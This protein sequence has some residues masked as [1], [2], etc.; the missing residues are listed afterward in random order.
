MCKR[1]RASRL[2]A[3][4]VCLAVTTCGTLTLMAQQRNNPA[5]A[6]AS[7]DTLTPGKVVGGFRAEAVYTNDSDRPMGARLR[8][9]RTGFTLDYLQLQSV[10][11]IFLWVNSFPTSD[12]GEPHTQEHLLLGKG[13]VGRAHSSLEGMT[14]VGSS[15]FTMQW[16]TCYFFHTAAGPEVFYDVFESQVN[17][18]LHPDYSDEEI[19]REV[20]NWGVAVNPADKTLRLEE[21]GTVYQEM[22]STY[23]RPASRL[24]R[25]VGHM[26][27]GTTHPLSVSSGGWPADIRRMKPE[28]IRK[29]HADTHHLGNMG[30]VGSFPR[31]M[32]LGQTLARLDEIFKRLE[33]QPAK[34]KFMTEAQLPAPK[35][36]PAGEIRI[37]EYPHRNEQQAGTILYAWPAQLKLTPQ[38]EIL[39]GL[40]L[41]NFAGDPTTNLYKKFVDTK[42]RELDIGAKSVFGFVDE[43]QGH[44][45]Y[46]GFGD[47]PPANM[48]TEKIQQARQKITDEIRR[49][50]SLADGSPELREFN[51]R[52]MNRVI[53]RR[54]DLSKFVNSPPG[55]GFRNTS[56]A[57][58][59][60]LRSL[61]EVKGF[62]KSVT[63]KTEMAA[64]E[65]QLASGKNFWRASIASWKLADSQPYAAAAKPNPE[66]IRRDE[67]EKAARVE[68]ETARLKTQYGVPDAQEALRRY[69]ADYEKTTAEL[70][71]AA[72]QASTPRFIESP[73]LTLDDQLDFQTS[74]L[75]GGVPMVA[76]TFDNMTSATTGLALRLDSVPEEELVYLSL[77]PFLLRNVG[78]VRDGRAVTFEEMSEMLRKEVLALDTYFSTNF[79]TGRAELVV[80]G[81]GND[82]EESKRALAWMRLLL[83]SPNWR[84]DNLARIRDVVDQQ[85][86]NLRNRMQGSEESW[87][88]DPADAYWRQ[89]SPVLLSTSSF[90]TRTHNAHRLRWMLKDAGEHRDAVAAFLEQL[91]T[92]GAQ[93]GAT[94]E[95]FKN[96]LGTLQTGELKDRQFNDIKSSFTALPDG[97]KA[98]VREAAKDLD[99]TLADLPDASLGADWS[100]LVRQIRHDLLVPPEKALADLN[101]LRQRLLKSGGA[102]MFM[103][104][105]RA[106]QEALAP[107]V[108]TLLGALEAGQAPAVKH[109][110]T[111]LVEARLRSRLPRAKEPVFVGLM[112]P[113]L[114]SGVFLNSAPGVT[115]ETTDRDALLDY[116]ASRLYAG[117][118]A[119]GIFIKT[120]GAGLAY[121]NGFRGSV[122]T[123]RLGYYAERTPELPQTLTFVIGELKRA[124]RD[125]SLT[126]YAIAQAFAEF[127][128]ASPY[129]QRGE[130]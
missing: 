30:M 34:M 3:T 37:V 38:D 81:A 49:I 116:L 47:V 57:W 58:M 121:S 45:V 62:R 72:K 52:L 19:R 39:L 55:F 100:Y 4:L 7:F 68:A 127:R 35:G 67:A 22:A 95:N 53:Q 48:T 60:H 6:D 59:S 126:E 24:F 13:N 75:A 51:E 76:S 122:G 103:T 42:T 93:Q 9:V 91:A 46:I 12:M 20:M 88:N 96:L 80:R 123:G 50:A 5:A 26:L 63:L 23:D 21:Q 74:T 43:D 70:E 11:Q 27:Y 69:K 2:L 10:P 44:P 109:A 108:R 94:R 89:D 113:N 78:V 87:V 105:S 64:I 8:H 25:S 128:S 129:E 124:P 33:P 106:S 14:L 54:R 83:T 120:W 36:A 119:H 99:Q 31:E 28:H 85:L 112:Q 18:L 73:P 114:T 111:R 61:E 16:R 130:A 65:R 118:G 110:D 71:R 77:M 17:A 1:Q 79:R 32:P 40:F 125:E 41:E 101:N 82:I 115:Y 102:R 97:A 15:A 90:L 86:G 66:V 104:G 98:V 56:S 92:A 29:F 107:G 84:P 117:R